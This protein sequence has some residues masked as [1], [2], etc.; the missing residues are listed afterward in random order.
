MQDLL[1]SSI[2]ELIEDS[3]IVFE[4]TGDVLW[5]TE[6][7]ARAL[8]A[9]RSVITLDPEFH[10][11][12]GSYFIGQGFL[13]EAEGDQPGC[14]A[15]F[16][17]EAVAMGFAP[18]VLGNMKG[19]LNHTPTPKEM[20]YWSTLQGLSIP[21]VTSFTD[22]TKLQVEQCLVGN[23][24]G[25][26]IVQDELMGPATDDLGEAARLLGEV[27]TRLRC[28]ITDYVLSRNLPHGVFIVA[29][30]KEEQR[31][32][33]NYLKLGPGPYYTL[34]R[35]N[36]FV[37]LEVFKT[38]ERLCRGQ[39]ALLTN[40]ERPKLSVAALAKD[41]LL[42]G[43]RIDRGA[44][45]FA[46]RGICVRMAEHPGHLPIGLAQDIV[47]R[48]RVEAGQLLTMDDVELPDSLAL[49]AWLT[50]TTATKVVL[51]KG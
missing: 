46:M 48:R 21:M 9:S 39:G 28:P 43:T 33:L 38:I 45:S 17:E 50:T 11:T 14:L 16:H 2:D 30:H 6:V 25:A 31:G 49:A 3:D 40:S 41:E 44:G 22:G 36:I 7:I 18:L 23:Y 35:S 42:P 12:A 19:F 26:D 10:I 4:C 13:S 5:A 34:V 15:A 20:Q 27:A 8:K 1:T 37:H 47:V 32:A 29:S 24:F 51:E